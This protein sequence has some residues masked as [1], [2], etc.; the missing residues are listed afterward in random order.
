MSKTILYILL[1]C[2]T[3]TQ[4]QQT[5][6]LFDAT[7]AESAGNADWIIDAG[8]HNLGYNN[9]PAVVG[10][11]SESNPAAVPAPAQSGING[12]TTETFWEG[13]LS[14]WGIDCVR[15]GYEV[16]SLPY[17][18]RITYG[19]I[20]NP[21]DLQNYSVYIVCEPNI[22][23]TS[24]EKTAILEFVN[25]GG[26][27][28]IIS[29]HD[30]SDRNG[31]GDDSP[32]IW[33]D[34]M[35][36][37]SVM[38]NPFGFTFTYSDIS[39][40]SSNV[41]TL[42]GDSVL[43]GPFGDVNMV[44]WS[45]GTTMTLSSLQNPSV[46]GLIYKSGSSQGNTNVLCAR[47]RFGRGKVVAIGDSSP[48]DDGSGDPNDFLYDGYIAD[49][50]GNHQKLL[51]NATIWLA[52]SDSVITSIPITDHEVNSISVYPNPADKYL[53]VKCKSDN[54]VNYTIE[55]ADTYGRILFRSDSNSLVEEK[56]H[57]R[58]DLENF[59]AGLYYLHY[60]SNLSSTVRPFIKL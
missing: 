51:M 50:N 30:Q 7:K 5:R 18:G 3:L 2:S 21:Q 53:N 15:Q 16:A 22:L 13:A 6:I 54:M 20:S 24:A 17:N 23:F 58:I 43:H 44:Q 1:F 57:L 9:G 55:I 12:S 42:P 60:Q 49:A 10:Q 11:G 46:T 34:L 25:N 59:S 41:A 52:T 28:F 47:A 36:T 48:C 27:L 40:T 4:A 35:N 8:L 26:G 32:H 29:D 45:N 14:Y 38:T 39:Q 31:D 56:N 19:D 37:N 33:N